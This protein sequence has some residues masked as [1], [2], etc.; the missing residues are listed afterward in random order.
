M[1]HQFV[2][3]AGVLASVFVALSV[4]LIAIDMVVVWLNFLPELVGY[5]KAEEIGEFMFTV[6]LTFVYV[7]LGFAVVLLASALIGLA[8]V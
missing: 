7:A 2:Q 4:A 3:L 6:A 5:R 8:F 1:F